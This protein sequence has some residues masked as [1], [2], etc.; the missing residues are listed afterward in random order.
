MIDYQFI[1]V[2]SLI[3]ILHMPLSATVSL[4]LYRKTRRTR[5]LLFWAAMTWLIPI[6]GAVAAIAACHRLAREQT[7]ITDS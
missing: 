5:D 1:Q 2:L 3:L 4:W 6:V 7:S